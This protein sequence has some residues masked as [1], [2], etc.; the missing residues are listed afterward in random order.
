MQDAF[1]HGL[2]ELL[3][4]LRRFALSLTRHGE[5]ADDLVQTACERALRSRSQWQEG[6]RLDAWM[7]RIIRNLWIDQV[8]ARASRG[9]SAPLDDVP[10]PMGEDGREVVESRLTL[11]AVE[12]AMASLSAEFR[13][14][15]ILVCVDGLSYKEAAERLDIPI[16]T[17]MS[18]LARARLALSARIAPL[19]HPASVPARVA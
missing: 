7:F 12:T 6:T 19:P 11:S 16:G 1:A 5:E 8:R 3:P 2:I 15:L 13:E 10:E 9:P 14:V 18:R 17:V 4:R